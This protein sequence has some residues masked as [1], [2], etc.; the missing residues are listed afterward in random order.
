MLLAGNGISGF[1]LFMYCLFFGFGIVSFFVVLGG[2]FDFLVVDV[3]FPSSVDN[4]GLELSGS[5]SSSL[6][7]LWRNNPDN[8]FF[9]CLDGSSS[10]DFSSSSRYDNITFFIDD[11]G[12]PL[13][14]GENFIEDVVVCDSIATLHSHPRGVCNTRIWSGD[15]ESAK[16]FFDAGGVFYIIMCGDGLFEVYDR[17]NGFNNGVVMQFD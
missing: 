16:S 5:V 10:M 12:A 3:S 2:F 1:G 9:V 7:T 4:V 17:D 14:G 15:V 8:E 13:V 11:V 6:D